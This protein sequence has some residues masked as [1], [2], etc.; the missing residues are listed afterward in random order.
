MYKAYQGEKYKLPRIG[1]FAEE[2]VFSQGGTGGTEGT[3]GTKDIPE[4]PKMEEEE[5]E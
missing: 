3:E 1:D 2:Q 5:E 4:A